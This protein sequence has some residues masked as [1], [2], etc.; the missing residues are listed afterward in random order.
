MTVSERVVCLFAVGLC[1]AQISSCCLT[2]L[3]QRY[4]ATTCPDEC[5]PSDGPLR[6]S[7][8]AVDDSLVLPFDLTGVWAQQEIASSLSSVPLVGDVETITTDTLLIRMVQSGNRVEMI[9]ESCG[10][11]SAGSSGAGQVVI[12]QSYTDA[13]DLAHR[14]AVIE[15]WGDGYRVRQE[16]FTRVMGAELSD[17]ENDPLPVAVDDPRVVDIDGDGK[18]GVTILM[19]GLLSGEIYMLQRSWIEVCGAVLSP[20]KLE[21]YIRWGTDQSVVDASS[22]FLE[23]NADS[24]PNPDWETQRFVACRVDDDMT[25]ADLFENREAVFAACRESVVPVERDSMSRHGS[26]TPRVACP[27]S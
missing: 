15:Q 19:D 10:M 21:G 24:V 9:T 23:N 8:L 18:P 3:A 1:S 11:D 7:A 5:F 22:L 13:M 6:L 25:C 12:P 26:A 20:D 2:P 16:R 27:T 17:I 14:N 4:P